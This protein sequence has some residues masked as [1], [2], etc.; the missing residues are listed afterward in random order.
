MPAIDSVAHPT[1]LVPFELTAP[2]ALSREQDAVDCSCRGAVGVCIEQQPQGSHRG[3]LGS[4]GT[5]QRT[6]R[7][8]S[9][10][11]E[12]LF[13][14]VQQVVYEAGYTEQ[15]HLHTGGSPMGHRASM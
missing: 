5:N 3:R 15:I 13:V 10:Q 1:V 11:E 7:A 14:C 8:H 9:V 2:I 12:K 4:E 6:Y